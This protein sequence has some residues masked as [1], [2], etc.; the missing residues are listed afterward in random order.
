MNFNLP[1]TLGDWV[2]ILGGIVIAHFLFVAGAHAGLWGTD[3]NG[4]IQLGGK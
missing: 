4:H 2:I 3:P 1:T